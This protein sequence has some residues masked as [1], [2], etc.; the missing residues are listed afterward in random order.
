MPLFAI[1]HVD[2]EYLHPGSC[3]LVEAA[4]LHAIA[5]PRLAHPKRWKPLLHRLYSNSDTGSY[6][7]WDRIQ[8]GALTPEELLTL[9]E[10]TYASDDQA[11]AMKIQPVEVQSL[12]TVKVEARCMVW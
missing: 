2:V 12:D 5:Q 8:L 4:S 10:Q 3:T 1:L 6:S 11:E 9:I 7:V